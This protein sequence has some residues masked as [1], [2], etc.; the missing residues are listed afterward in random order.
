MILDFMPWKDNA[1]DRLL[2]GGE[3]GA[4]RPPHL[5][6]RLDGRVSGPPGKL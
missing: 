3:G 6:P 1:E 5:P 2:A 4:L